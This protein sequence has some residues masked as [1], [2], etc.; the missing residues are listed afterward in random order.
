MADLRESSLLFSLAA[1]NE[2]EKERVQREADDARKRAEAEQRARLEAQRESAR[3]VAEREERARAAHS[4]EERACQTELERLEAA[5]LAEF[6]RAERE[7]RSRRELEV[8]LLAQARDERQSELATAARVGKERTR[9]LLAVMGWV[10]SCAALTAW[11]CG[12]LRP[13]ADALRSSYEQRLAH[14][15]DVRQAAEATAGRA[16]QRA[17]TM[18]ERVA[19]LEGELRDARQAKPDFAGKPRPT[20]GSGV[21]RAPT[22]VTTHAPC[23]DDGDPL[24]P[25]LKR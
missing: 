7:A 21:G 4:A 22:P 10:L 5:R 11:Y 15:T 14:E 3:L 8:S 6:E 16:E 25:C 1:L 19:S 2:R 24:N 12:K 17:Q 20:S 9:A 18:G 23:R 13:D